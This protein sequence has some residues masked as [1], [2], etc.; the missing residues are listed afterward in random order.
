MASN[1]WSIIFS[2]HWL[3]FIIK[4]KINYN[5]YRG[6]HISPSGSSIRVKYLEFQIWDF[7]ICI[8]I[9][10]VGKKLEYCRW[11]VLARWQNTFGLTWSSICDSDGFNRRSDSWKNAQRWSCEREHV[12]SSRLPAACSNTTEVSTEFFVISKFFL[13][14]CINIISR[15]SPVEALSKNAAVHLNKTHWEKNKKYWNT[16]FEFSAGVLWT[17]VACLY[18]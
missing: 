4:I 13:L 15:S 6:S 10:N 1:K 11:N 9:C 5:S 16:L 14:S 3:D 8:W 18:I 7:G 17:R 12:L 2:R